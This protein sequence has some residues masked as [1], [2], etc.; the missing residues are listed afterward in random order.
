MGCD[1]QDTHDAPNEVACDRFRQD[2]DTL[3]EV[4]ECGHERRCHPSEDVP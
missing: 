4:C 2:G 3:A 1:C